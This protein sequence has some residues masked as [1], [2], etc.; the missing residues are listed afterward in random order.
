MY[1]ELQNL[2]K[3]ACSFTPQVQFYDSQFRSIGHETSGKFDVDPTPFPVTHFRES[4]FESIAKETEQGGRDAL[5]MRW[6][7]N[8]RT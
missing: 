3:Q 7:L 1:Y 8:L 5:N 6:S 4:H 2:E